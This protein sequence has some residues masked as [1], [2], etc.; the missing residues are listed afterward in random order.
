MRRFVVLACVAA[1][2]DPEAPPDMSVEEHGTY[3]VGTAR[4]TSDGRTLQV[5]YPT[6][7]AETDVAIESLEDE[8]RR[9]DYAS[10]L[11]AADPACPTRR[12]SVA[13]DAAPAAGAFPLVV[14]SHCYTCTRLNLATV[15]ARLAS[16]GF[17]VLSVDHDGATLWN[18]L[19][20]N[21]TGLSSEALDARISDMQAALAADHASLASVDRTRI[22]SLGHSFGAVTAGKLA[23]LDERIGATFALAAPI[24]SPLFPGVA[25]A[26]IP[27][28]FFVARE[29]NSISEF[30]NNF[31]RDNFQ[32]AARAAWKLEVTDAGHW[33]VSDLV[34][35]VDG[36]AAGCGM[37]IRQTDDTPFTYL[38]PATGR[39]ITA[40]YVTAFFRATLDDDA[41]AR[42]YL[43]RSFPDE[44]TVVIDRHD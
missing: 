17:V 13:A 36:F 16:H 20:M 39:A 14:V 11:A 8:P 22:G 26:P 24:D 40:S 10:L 21:Q 18:L 5:F 25:L 41:G 4:F 38:A 1:C 2:S 7:V 30:G 42:G 28:A 34:G 19:A 9:T 33:T 31:I 32:E 44:N 23:Q 3:S 15:S 29:D 12:L 37:D 35:V 43:A 6:D 27:M